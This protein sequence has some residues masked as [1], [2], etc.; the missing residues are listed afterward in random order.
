MGQ[1]ELINAAT[2]ADFQKSKSRG[3]R[4]AAGCMFFIAVVCVIAAPWFFVKLL[5]AAVFV[6]LGVLI[7]RREVK[8]GELKVYFIKRP[9]TDKF[10]DEI[11]D[12]EDGTQDRYNLVFDDKRFVAGFPV[13]DDANVGDEYYV[14]YDSY[15]NKI[16]NVYSADKY[17]ISPDLDI[18]QS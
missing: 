3:A 14:M 1:K 8:R 10:V 2:V 16:I 4:I 13:F 12:A 6:A 15:D 11:P 9:L 5:C 17:D 7:L 18:R